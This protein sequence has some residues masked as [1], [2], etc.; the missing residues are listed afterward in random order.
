[1]GNISWH[2][3]RTKLGVGEQIFPMLNDE[4]CNMNPYAGNITRSE[5][6][7]GWFRFVKNNGPTHPGVDMPGP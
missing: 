1:M 2:L 7:K 4:S 5:E 3:T 6:A